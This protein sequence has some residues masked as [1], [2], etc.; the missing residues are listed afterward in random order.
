MDSDPKVKWEEALG[1]S[2]SCHPI[3]HSSRSCA[4]NNVTNSIAYFNYRNALGVLRYFDI[5]N[6]RNAY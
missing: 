1:I 4:A 6:P 2:D 3:S 5:I